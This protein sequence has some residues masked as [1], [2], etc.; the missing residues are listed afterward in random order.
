MW[1]SILGMKAGRQDGELS[2]ALVGQRH[3]ALRPSARW[4]ILPGRSRQLRNTWVEMEATR[5]KTLNPEVST[6]V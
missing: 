2:L 3:R 6:N 4:S 5:N 1:L